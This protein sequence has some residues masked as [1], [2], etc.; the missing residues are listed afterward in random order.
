MMSKKEQ[1]E[2]KLS[3]RK[4]LKNLNCIIDV[5]DPQQLET[6]LQKVKLLKGEIIQAQLSEI[7]G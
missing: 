6:L 7:T 5:I 3:I 2:M 1:H 4:E